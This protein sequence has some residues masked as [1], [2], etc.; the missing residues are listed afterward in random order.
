M[1]PSDLPRRDLAKKPS[2]R[3]I[4]AAIFVVGLLGAGRS[5]F[6]AGHQRF[7]TFSAKRDAWHQ[8]CDARRAAG[9]AADPEAYDSCN[10]EMEAL[11]AEGRRS[12]WVE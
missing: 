5:Y 2:A 6:A 3:W 12:G 7:L 10:R 9:R 8:R 1:S 4:W 11:D